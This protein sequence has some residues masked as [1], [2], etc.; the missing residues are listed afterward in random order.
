MLKEPPP[1]NVPPPEIEP[2]ARVPVEKLREPR[3]LPFAEVAEKEPHAKLVSCDPF[4]A[5]VDVPIVPNPFVPVMP[6]IAIVP[7]SLVVVIVSA[8]AAIGN[9]SAS[10]ARIT[11]TRLMLIPPRFC[12][13]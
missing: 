9:V 13:N 2:V 7:V 11:T 1:L 8:H 4:E 5:I 6:V 10:K 3:A 12:L